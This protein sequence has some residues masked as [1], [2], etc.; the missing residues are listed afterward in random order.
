MSARLGEIDYLEERLEQ[1]IERMERAFS[2]L[3]DEE[4]D[5]DLATLAAQLGRLHLFSGA[6]DL[7]AARIEFALVLAERLRLPE[8]LSQA[9]NTKAV[10]LEFQGRH[11]EA[12]ALVRHALKVALDNDLSASA[13]RAYNNLGAFLFGNDRYAEARELQSPVTRARPAGGRPWLRALDPR[14]RRDADD[15][16]R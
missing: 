10:L 15:R 13:L 7:A 5:A 9:L 4:P 6:H 11:E 3:A 12:M 16:S 8:Q 1:G 2:L 14:R